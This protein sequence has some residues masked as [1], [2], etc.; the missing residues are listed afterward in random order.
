MGLEAGIVTLE[1]TLAFNTRREYGHEGRLWRKNIIGSVLSIVV[2]EL[3]LQKNQRDI[4]AK[5]INQ[6]WVKATAA[7]ICWV[8]FH[9]VPYW[10]CNILPAGN[11]TR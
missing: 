6:T 8:I 1:M 5:Q 10:H 9:T 3:D 2:V 7:I 11:M 4:L